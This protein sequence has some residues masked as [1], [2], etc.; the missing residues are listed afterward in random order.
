VLL[1]IIPQGTAASGL[2]LANALGDVLYRLGFQGVADI[3]GGADQYVTVAELYQWADEGAKKL[4]YAAGVFVTVD[5]SITVASPTAVYAL[6]GTHVFTLMA[7]LAGVPLRIT[8]VRELE[9]LDATWPATSGPATR[10]SFDA[11]AVGVV[12]LYPLP[13]VGGT[14]AQ[15]CQEFPATI[16][17]GSSTLGLPTV[18][19]DYFSYAM[20]AGARGKE[21]DAAMP[22]MA[23][24]FEE[25]MKLYE[26]VARELW[27]RGQ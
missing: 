6:P 5:T 10:C 27:G 21:S 12:T 13:T 19:Q 23:A 18:M 1:L 24:H 26:Q 20:M 7:A 14:L 2:D 22:E 11:G 25:R 17:Q 8:P 4:S 3:T 9:A 16:A 15:I